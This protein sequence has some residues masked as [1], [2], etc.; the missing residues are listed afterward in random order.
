LVVDVLV[1]GEDR[2]CRAPGQ[3]GERLDSVALRFQP[4]TLVRDS[5]ALVVPAQLATNTHLSFTAFA[6]PTT[7]RARY[8]PATQVVVAQC[9]PDIP[10][11]R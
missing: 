4:R 9:T 6:L 8:S 7:G 2:H 3:G 11:C 1:C 5:F 10:A